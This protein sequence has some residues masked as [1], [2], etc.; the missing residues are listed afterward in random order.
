MSF[1]PQVGDVVCDCRF[2]HLR[3]AERNG[4]DLVLEDGARCSLRYCCDPP[5]HECPHPRVIS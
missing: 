1:D 4:D 5:D 2:R 3:I